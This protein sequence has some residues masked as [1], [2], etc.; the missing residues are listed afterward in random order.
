MTPEQFA[1]LYDAHAPLVR[2]LLGRW[3]APAQLDDLTQEAFL[4]AW[5]ARDSFRG[6]AQ[7]KTWIC[8]IARNAAIDAARARKARG[9][10][11]QT[12]VEALDQRAAPGLLPEEQALVRDALAS[13][14]P[15]DR[16]LLLLLSVEQCTMAEIAEILDIPEG[17]V[18]SRA[19]ALRQRLRE[20]LGQKGAA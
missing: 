13:M 5:R 16:A 12:G 20:Q 18:K 9:E 3:C 10:E 19:F 1:A 7:A 4:R 6:E 15:D 17:T 14:Q 8:R 2:A 11:Q